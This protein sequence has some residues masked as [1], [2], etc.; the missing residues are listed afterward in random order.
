MTASGIWVASRT[1]DQYSVYK[2]GRGAVGLIRVSSSKHITK[3]KK[4]NT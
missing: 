4:N 3:S 1:L 2:H